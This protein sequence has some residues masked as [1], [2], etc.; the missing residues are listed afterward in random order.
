MIG[1]FAS[2]LPDMG[3]YALFI[4]S[5]YAIG[6]AG[7]IFLG[8]SSWRKKCHLENTLNNAK[9]TKNKK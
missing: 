1:I 8:F 9:K 7:L 3:S 2:I 4:W 5:S 6:L